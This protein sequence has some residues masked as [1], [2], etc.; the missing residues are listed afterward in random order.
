MGTAL[1]CTPSG[2]LT[3]R[4]WLWATMRELRVFTLRELCRAVNIGRD[5]II[6]HGKAGDYLR[7]G[8]GRHRDPGRDR[9]GWRKP[10]STP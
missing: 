6:T 8:P 5:D 1:R 2:H 7:A 10:T 4:E 9:D 3:D